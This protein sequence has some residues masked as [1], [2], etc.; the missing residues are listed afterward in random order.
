MPRREDYQRPEAPPRL[1][2][3]FGMEVTTRPQGM[4]RIRQRL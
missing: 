3:S 1:I 2:G 4:V